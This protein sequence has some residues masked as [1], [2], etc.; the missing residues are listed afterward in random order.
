MTIVKPQKGHFV[1][2]HGYSVSTNAARGWAAE[3]FKR[4]WQS[5]S[6]S[7]FTA[8]DWFGDDSIG[9]VSMPGHSDDAP[10]YY[11]NVEHAFASAQRFAADCSALDEAKR[12]SPECR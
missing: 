3:M 2:V 7:R 12:V 6:R 1:F 10:N 4:L 11:V 9:T 5:G 8:L